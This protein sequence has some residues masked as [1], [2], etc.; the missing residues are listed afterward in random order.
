[1]AGIGS[2][3]AAVWLGSRSGFRHR[4][5]LIYLP[6]IACALAASSLGLPVPVA[7]AGALMLTVGASL[8]TLEL[9]WADTLKNS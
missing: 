8:T 2:V 1:M 3:C 4:G 9:V 7:A 5:R 6:W